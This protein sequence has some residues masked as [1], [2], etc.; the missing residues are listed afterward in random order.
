MT[1]FQL[2]KKQCIIIITVS[3]IIIIILLIVYW[4]ARIYQILAA[5]QG[6]KLSAPM[7]ISLEQSGLDTIHISW[8]P[9]IYAIKYRIFVGLQPNFSRE[10]AL[11]ADIVTQTPEFNPR[12]SYPI[13]NDSSIDEFPEILHDEF[14]R[15]TL[16][17]GG[18][19]TGR[20]YYIKIEA[21]NSCH[22]PGELSR[23]FDIELKYPKNFKI[24]N[25]YSPDVI[26]FSS[27][28]SI[29]EKKQMDNFEYD[30]VKIGRAHV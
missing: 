23:E 17:I 8:I 7:R 28:P 5:E 21:I 9:V 27:H 25:R 18:L 24:V 10:T 22:N 15:Q 3:L 30:K 19:I 1:E 6:E 26:A 13:L 12:K 14:T 29:G 4:R 16:K 2:S 20:R 11:S